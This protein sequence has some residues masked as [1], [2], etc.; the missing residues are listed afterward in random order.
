MYG[1]WV[2][3]IQ[4]MKR[5]PFSPSDHHFYVSTLLENCNKNSTSVIWPCLHF[6]FAEKRSSTRLFASFLEKRETIGKVNTPWSNSQLALENYMYCIHSNFPLYN[7]VDTFGVK[8]FCCR[9]TNV[10]R[11]W[12]IVNP[13]STNEL[14]PLKTWTFTYHGQGA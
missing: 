14:T 11:L 9:I 13:F 12:S 10:H 6:F 3:W 2:R 8:V 1:A 7:D 4:A 5:N